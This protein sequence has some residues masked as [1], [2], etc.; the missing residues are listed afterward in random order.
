MSLKADAAKPDDLANSTAYPFNE[1]GGDLPGSTLV[2]GNEQTVVTE[3]TT[4]AD[5][6]GD[7]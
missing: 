4:G 3:G 7:I 5:P 6:S 2:V 1:S